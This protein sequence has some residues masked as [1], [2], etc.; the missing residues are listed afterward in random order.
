MKKYINLNQ[1]TN[2]INNYLGKVILFNLFYICLYI[3]NLFFI[4]ALIVNLNISIIWFRWSWYQLSWLYPELYPMYLIGHLTLHLNFLL[5]FF[6][7]I[8]LGNGYTKPVH[9]FK[10]EQTSWAAKALSNFC[11]DFLIKFCKKFSLSSLFF[12]H[13]CFSATHP[14]RLASSFG[15]VFGCFMSFKRAQAQDNCK[16]IVWPRQSD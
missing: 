7:Y 5:L 10:K 11:F 6:V 9:P 16:P 12:T 15:H 8:S 3:N 2:D 4:P 14:R 13:L 1:P